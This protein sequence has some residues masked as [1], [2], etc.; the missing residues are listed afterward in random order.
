MNHLF[1]KIHLDRIN[2]TLSI[3]GINQYP[4]QKK[5]TSS[6]VQEAQQPKN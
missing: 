3:Y 5:K 1:G 2:K 4:E 6:R